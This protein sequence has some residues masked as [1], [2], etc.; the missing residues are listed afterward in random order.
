MLFPGTWSLSSFLNVSVCPDIYSAQVATLNFH[1]HYLLNTIRS[2]IADI[3]PIPLLQADSIRQGLADNFCFSNL[4]LLLAMLCVV[5]LLD[6]SQKYPCK[7]GDCHQRRDKTWHLPF[8]WTLFTLGAG[9]PWMGT[10]LMVTH[11]NWSLGQ[12]GPSQA[13]FINFPQGLL[14]KSRGWQKARTEVKLSRNG[15][16]HLGFSD[17]V[18]KSVSCVLWCTQP[19]TEST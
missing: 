15:D 12:Q 14:L 10:S 1:W 9:T 2:K 4:W 3:F 17:S 7:T 6:Q 13:T 11:T 16:E 8:N 19:Q 5:F 18:H